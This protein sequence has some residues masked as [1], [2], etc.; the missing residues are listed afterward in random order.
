MGFTQR[1]LQRKRYYHHHRHN[2]KTRHITPYIGTYNSFHRVSKA[3][4]FFAHFEEEVGS[5][6]S[7]GEPG[8]CRDHQC[9]DGVIGNGLPGG[10]G[11]G[12][13]WYLG[14]IKREN[15]KNGILLER[16]KKGTLHC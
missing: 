6:I 7:S 15:D 5:L 11:E 8:A 4:W 14:G 9:F 3:A 1:R 13:D 16:G 10:S 2:K 12:D